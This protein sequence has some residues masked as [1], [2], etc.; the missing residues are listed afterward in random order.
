MTNS[1]EI[2]LNWLQER[3]QL[4]QTDLR[5][6]R[7]GLGSSYMAPAGAFEA[8]FDAGCNLFYW[9]ALRT[10]QMTK[11]MRNII[12]S[13]RR[14]KIVIAL[15]SYIRP[16][17]LGWSVRRGLR[18][19][20]IER[21]DILLLGGHNKEPSPRFIDE[22]MRLKEKG[23]FRYLGITGHHRPLLA[24][25]A[26]DGRFDLFMLRYTAAHR[27]AEKDV[28]PF[29]PDKP[30][31][32]IAFTA[33]RWKSLIKPGK[34]PEGE[35]IPT[36]GDCYRFVLSHSQVDVTITAPSSLKQMKEN[37]I[38]TAKGPMTEDELAWMRRVGDAVYGK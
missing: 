21:A 8:A 4:G 15:Q 6:G 33:T 26:G 13:G 17:G 27:G 10:P 35:K 36:A 23:L 29:L 38:E 2:K 20:G 12:A 5:A 28:F 22:A 19:L 9:G 14:D 31:G 18:R 7:L 24:D 37:L 30:P 11:A 3:I 32:I 1:A 34:I 16:R 25:L